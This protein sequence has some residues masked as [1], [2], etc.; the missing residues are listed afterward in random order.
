MTPASDLIPCGAGRWCLSGNLDFTTV[1]SLIAEI[2]VLLRNQA[3]QRCT[4]L[5]FDLSGLESANS[6]G[7][8]FL[9]ECVELAQAQG[10][11]LTWRQIPDALKRIAAVSNLE[12]IL[13]V[14]S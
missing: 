1:T 2:T 10:I 6:A 8:A 3:R 9:L 4:E 7:L 13:P 14:M 12:G 11:R 5:E